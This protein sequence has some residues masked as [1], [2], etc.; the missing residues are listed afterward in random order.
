MNFANVARH[1]FVQSI[2][3]HSYPVRKYLSENR[4]IVLIV[5]LITSL[6]YWY[7]IRPVRIHR[8]CAAQASLDAKNLL[9]SKAEITTD[10]AKRASYASL[11]EKG[12]YLRSDYESFFKKCMR[13]YAITPAE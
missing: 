5:L 13:H 9:V 11:S 12:M 4:N 3:T 2:R 6:F 8:V 10:A 1:P 7:E